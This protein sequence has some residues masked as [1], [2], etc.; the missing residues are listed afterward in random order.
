MTTTRT[1]TTS[2]ST[3]S[4]ARRGL[5]PTAGWQRLLLQWVG[6]ILEAVIARLSQDHYRQHSNADDDGDDG[7]RHDD[8]DQAQG[9]DD[10]YAH[11]DAKTALM[12]TTLQWY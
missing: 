7:H 2:G 4:T 12:L 6:T 9:Q 1:A 5:A 3:G 10:D 8:H 11:G